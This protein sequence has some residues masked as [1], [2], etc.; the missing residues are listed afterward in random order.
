MESSKGTDSAGARVII[1][2]DD[3]AIR[4]MFGTALRG[5]GFD[6]EE[7]ADGDEAYQAYLR[8]CPDLLLADLVMPGLNGEELA[9]RCRERCPEAALVFMSGY[10]EEELHE[11]D[12]RQ[13][14]FLPKPISP[15]DLIAVVRRLVGGAKGAA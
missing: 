14:V 11:L 2:D 12:I 10:T 1:A 8:E 13:V 15:R 9:R 7:A 6:V 5:A 4:K 3:A